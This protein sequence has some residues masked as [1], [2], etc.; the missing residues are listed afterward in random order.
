MFFL[1]YMLPNIWSC[2]WFLR[3]SEDLDKFGCIQSAFVFSAYCD[4]KW[5]APDY[6]LC[7]K[8]II[9]IGKIV[10]YDL[11]HAVPNAEITNCIG[12]RNN[13][14]KVHFFTCVHKQG[15]PL[16]CAWI[17]WKILNIY[18]DKELIWQSS[19]PVLFQ[20]FTSQNAPEPIRDSKIWPNLA[21][22]LLRNEAKLSTTSPP[23][24]NNIHNRR[25]TNPIPDSV[26]FWKTFLLKF[27]PFCVKKSGSKLCL[28]TKNY[29]SK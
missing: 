10:T 2:L 8:R 22:P 23:A 19:V 13:A 28:A 21:D 14:L 5:F 26:F 29:I 20:Y 27:E 15:M 9:K 17:R 3:S 6:T 16:I 24:I 25:F 11:W 7:E 1:C 4:I 18:S 12:Q